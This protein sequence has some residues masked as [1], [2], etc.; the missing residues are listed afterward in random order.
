MPGQF[1]QARLLRRVPPPLKELP[2]LTR[3]FRPLRELLQQFP[4]KLPRRLPREGQRQDFSRLHPQQHQLHNPIRQPE[5]FPRPR[6]RRDAQMRKSNIHASAL[7]C[8]YGRVS[9][10][11][12]GRL[13]KPSAPKL[14]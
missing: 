7:H 13:G 12:L 5:R 9:P 10:R 8:G 3:L 1:L 2:R 4:Q 11:V 14:S 6:R